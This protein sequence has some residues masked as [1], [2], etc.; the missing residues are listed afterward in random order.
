MKTLARATAVLTDDHAGV[1]ATVCTILEK[2]FE[3]AALTIDGERALEA[4]R[5]FLPDLIVLDITMPGWNGFETALRISEVSPMTRVLFLT[6]YE[7]IDYMDRARQMGASCVIKRRMQNDLLDAA[8][9]AL[10]GKLFFSDL[11][12]KSF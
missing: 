7:D 9:D 3:I 12:K 10:A 6:A 5:R 11:Q 1:L 4:V 8:R 2:E